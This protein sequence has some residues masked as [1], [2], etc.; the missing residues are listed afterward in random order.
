MITIFHPEG[1]APASAAPASEGDDFHTLSVVARTF[2][3]TARALRYYEQIG[4]IEADRDP[5]NRRIFGPVARARLEVICPLSR[6]GVPLE[7]VSGILSSTT[8][9]PAELLAHTL[10]GQLRLLNS[11]IALVRNLLQQARARTERPHLRT[12]WD[13]A[14]ADHLV[15][16]P[17]APGTALSRR[18]PPRPQR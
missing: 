18:A 11:K 3:L 1:R 8:P 16:G 5:L 6:A 14:R 17:T 4:L 15:D 9:A 12:V 10:E 2:G 7:V 13:A